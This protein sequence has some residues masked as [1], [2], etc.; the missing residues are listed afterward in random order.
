MLE[1]LYSFYESNRGDEQ[2]QRAILRVENRIYWAQ[3]QRFVDIS[4]LDDWEYINEHLS[5]IKKELT[6]KIE[7]EVNTRNVIRILDNLYEQLQKTGFLFLSG[8]KFVNIDFSIVRNL[9]SWLNEQYLL[10]NKWISEYL[11]IIDNQHVYDAA[12]NIK[13]GYDIIEMKGKVQ[14]IL[15]YMSGTNREHNIIMK[16]TEY[17]YMIDCFYYF[18]DHGCA[19]KA[20]RSVTCRLN[21][22]VISYTL[23]VLYKLIYPNDSSKRKE[24]LLFICALFDKLPSPDELYHNFSRRSEEFLKYYFTGNSEELLEYIR[25]H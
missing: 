6:E 3:I 8:S 20:M 23:Y 4:L 9:N 13:G 25:S 12:T 11:P 15:Q 2:I 14:R 17:Q 16:P 21:I 10:Y 24:W 7:C 1:R 22:G 19:P 18:I 5:K